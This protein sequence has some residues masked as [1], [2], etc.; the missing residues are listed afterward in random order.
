[1]M[2]NRSASIVLATLLAGCPQTKAPAESAKP[3]RPLQ[4]PVVSTVACPTPTPRADST[5]SLDKAAPMPVPLAAFAA[6]ATGGNLYVAGGAMNTNGSVTSHETFYSPLDENGVPG[7]WKTTAQIPGSIMQTSMAGFRGHLYLVGGAVSAVDRNE[8]IAK[9]SIGKIGKGGA[10]ESWIAGP[11]LPEPSAGGASVV[12]NG[13]LYSI[14]GYS[15]PG[16]GTTSTGAVFVSRILPDGSLGPW[17]ATHAL[18]GG[19]FFTSAAGGGKSIYVVGGFY[20]LSAT[21]GSFKAGSRDCEANKVLVGAQDADGMI[22]SWSQAT[23]FAQ[24]VVTASV[25]VVDNQLVVAGGFSHHHPEGSQEVIAA[26]IGADG[27]PGAWSLVA[28]LPDS[29]TSRGGAYTDSSLYVLGGNS[30]FGGKAALLPSTIQIAS[31]TGRVTC[32]AP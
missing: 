25:G 12:L 9:V 7:T 32:S 11:D 5:C 26:P 18:P 14:A 8:P 30:M 31:R 27:M 21:I 13:F 1:M 3:V 10:V 19:R 29:G 20:E 24:E 28:Y 23:T 16:G 17:R 22:T 4:P 15:K 6:A 2:A